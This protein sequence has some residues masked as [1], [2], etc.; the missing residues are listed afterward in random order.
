MIALFKNWKNILLICSGVVFIVGFYTIKLNQATIK[1]QASKLK[2]LEI[3]VKKIY[4]KI[5]N[6][7]QSKPFPIGLYN[8][9]QNKIAVFY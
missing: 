6:K 4:L 5:K 7:H 9:R 1:Q 8:L 3:K 2:N